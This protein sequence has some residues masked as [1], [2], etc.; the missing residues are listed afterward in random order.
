V[1]RKP[2]SFSI[3]RMAFS[4]AATTSS[5]AWI[6]LSMAAIT[7]TLVEGTWLKML[8]YQCTMHRCQAAWGKNSAALSESP[9]QASE[10]ISRTPLLGTS[11]SSPCP[12]ALADAENLP[13]TL[14][15]HADRHQKR[16]I[17]N[18]AGPAALEH[19][20]IEINIGVLALDRPTSSSARCGAPAGM[21]HIAGRYVSQI[22]AATP[23]PEGIYC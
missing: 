13:I 22:T 6:V 21:D 11:S 20:A 2:R 18:L 1:K 19:D 15:V 7:R 17:A 16:H 14:A 23:A 12:H 9:R 4:R 8:R 5:L 3:T 10:M